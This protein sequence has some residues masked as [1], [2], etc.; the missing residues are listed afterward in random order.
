MPSECL[1]MILTKDRNFI[2]DVKKEWEETKAG[3]YLS[4]VFSGNFISCGGLVI[5]IQQVDCPSCGNCRVDDLKCVFSKVN[6]FLTR[7]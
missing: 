5:F 3:T 7:T 1:F 6:D 4:L 2:E